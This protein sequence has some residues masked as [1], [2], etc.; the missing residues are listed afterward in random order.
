MYFRGST[1]H[2]RSPGCRCAHRCLRVCGSSI[3]GLRK[4]APGP[5]MS[6]ASSN[7]PRIA[8]NSP[9]A[10][11]CAGPGTQTCHP[12]SITRTASR[13]GEML[14]QLGLGLLA[15]VRKWRAADRDCDDH[16]GGD[17]DHRQHS[18]IRTNA[19]KRFPSDPAISRRIRIRC[20]EPAQQSGEA[21][22]DPVRPAV[23]RA[24][25]RFRRESARRHTGDNREGRVHVPP[26][27]RKRSRESARGGQ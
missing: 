15:V 2:R 27:R 1:G 12:A 17:T 13:T 3:S 24:G 16:D 10:T 21:S 14:L 23:L 25:T 5:G 20:P 7:A 19:S 22:T 18:R 26:A 11:P 8:A 9:Q 4:Y 6:P